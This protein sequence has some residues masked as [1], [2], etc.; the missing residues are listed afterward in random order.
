MI[1]QITNEQT[2]SQGKQGGTG[3]LHITSCEVTLPHLSFTVKIVCR[4]EN[5]L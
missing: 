3:T 2:T 1:L 4:Q 5:L